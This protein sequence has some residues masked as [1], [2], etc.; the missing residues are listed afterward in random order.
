[1]VSGHT[2][3]RGDRGAGGVLYVNRGAPAPGGSTTPLSIALLQVAVLPRTR[4]RRILGVDTCLSPA[5]LGRRRSLWRSYPEVAPVIR[6]HTAGA[7]A[8]RYPQF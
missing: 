3:P 1:V 2:P 5:S 6:W 8:E 4:D 7:A